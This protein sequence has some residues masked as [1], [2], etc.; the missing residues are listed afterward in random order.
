M[1]TLLLVFVQIYTVY[2]FFKGYVINSFSKFLVAF[3]FG[4]ASVVQYIACN[5]YI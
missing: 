2:R 1:Q 4:G 3:N 5:I